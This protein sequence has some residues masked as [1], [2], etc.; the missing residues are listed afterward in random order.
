MWRE[1]TSVLSGWLACHFD[2]LEPADVS[3]FPAS[4]VQRLLD[5]RSVIH[6]EEAHSVIARQ[7]ERVQSWLLE[8]DTHARGVFGSQG[9][10]EEKDRLLSMMEKWTTDKLGFVTAQV[11]PLQEMRLKVQED[12]ESQMLVVQQHL[13]CSPEAA[14]EAVA[15]FEHVTSLSDSVWQ[16]LKPRLEGLKHSI[17]LRHED[18][19]KELSEA[20]ELCS[21]SAVRKYLIPA[22][23]VDSCHCVSRLELVRDCIKSKIAVAKGSL[24]TSPALFV[25]S[26]HRLKAA[27]N[28]VGDLLLK[29]DLE[30]DKELDKMKGFADDYV[31]KQ[32]DDLLVDVRNSNVVDVLNKQQ[33][34]LEVHG[35][36]TEVLSSRSEDSYRRVCDKVSGLFS[37]MS[38]NVNQFVKGLSA[39]AQS[40]EGSRNEAATRVFEAVLRSLQQLFVAKERSNARDLYASLL[41][42]LVRAI[43]EFHRVCFNETLRTKTFAKGIESYQCLQGFMEKGLGKHIPTLDFSIADVIQE[44]RFKHNSWNREFEQHLYTEQTIVEKIKPHLKH[45]FPSFWSFGTV[46]PLEYREATMVIEA[47]IRRCNLQNLSTLDWSSIAAA[48][49]MLC[50]IKKHLVDLLPE[51]I[52]AAVRRSLGHL[53][54]HF[55]FRVNEVVNAAG[56]G[57]VMHLEICF[58]RFSMLLHHCHRAFLKKDIEAACARVHQSILSLVNQSLS[59]FDYDLERLEVQQ[60]IESWEKLEKLTGFFATKFAWHVSD[61]CDMCEWSREGKALKNL[62]QE[63]FGGIEVQKYWEHCQ[64]LGVGPSQSLQEV[65]QAWK[66]QSLRAHPDQN[67]GKPECTDIQKQLNSAHHTLV[68]EGGFKRF[69]DQFNKLFRSRLLKLPEVLKQEIRNELEAGSYGRVRKLLKVL[70]DLQ[71]LPMASQD[72]PS[73]LAE[74]HLA[75]REEV[76]KLKGLISPLW[77]KQDFPA[78]QKVLGKLAQMEECF[79]AFGDIYTDTWRADVDQKVQ[80]KLDTYVKQARE[81][82][83]GSVADRDFNMMLFARQLLL[84]ARVLDHLAMYRQL[85]MFKISHLLDS[86]QKQKGG[87]C[88][89]F[90]LGMLLEQGKCGDLEDGRVCAEDQRLSKEIVSTFNHFS[91]VRTTIFNQQTASSAQKDLEEILRDFEVN[92][93]RNVA[94]VDAQVRP[95]ELKAAYTLYKAAYDKFLHW[96]RT[97]VLETCPDKIVDDIMNLAAQVAPKSSKV[98]SSKLK[99]SLPILLAGVGILLAGFCFLLCW[100]VLKCPTGR[101]YYCSIKKRLARYFFLSCLFIAKPSKVSAQ[102]SICKSGDRILQIAGST[103]GEDVVPDDVR[104]MLKQAHRTQILACLRLLGFDCKNASLSSHLMRIRTGEGKSIIVGLCAVVLSLLGFTSRCV[105]YSEYLSN[106]DFQDFL[107]VFQR[108]KVEDRVSYSK[109]TKFSEDRALARGNLRQFTEDLLLG[110]DISKAGRPEPKKTQSLAIKSEERTRPCK[111]QL[112]EEQQAEKKTCKRKRAKENVTKN[113]LERKPTKENMKKKARQ[114]SQAACPASVASIVP[115]TDAIVESSAFSEPGRLTPLNGEVILLVDEVDV[116]FGPD[117]FGK[118]YNQV[119]EVALPEVR[120]LL[121]MIWA[122]RS[123]KDDFRSLM[124]RVQESS[125]YAALQTRLADWDV[126]V[127]REVASMCAALKDM[128]RKEVQPEYIWKENRIGYKILDSVDADV[129]FGYTTAFHYLQLAESSTLRDKESALEKA[130]QL[131]I[132]CA[133][134]SYARFGSPK[135]LGVSGTVHELEEYK[136][137][138][139]TT[140]GLSCYSDM[141]SVYGD[142]N[143]RFLDQKIGNPI[144]VSEEKD[145][146]LNIAGSIRQQ[147]SAKR[148]VIAF[149]ENS[150]KLRDF[151]DSSH[152]R[153]LADVNVLQETLDERERDRVIRKAATSSQVTLATAVFGRGT[154]FFCHD[155]ELKEAGGVHVIQTFL[156][157]DKA[158]EV[159]I[160]GRTAR[161]GEDGSYAMVLSMADLE[162]FGIARSICT[163]APAGQ[164]GMLEAARTAHQKDVRHKVNEDG[165][166]CPT[167]Q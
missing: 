114:S 113:A 155:P 51:G 147:V 104:Q 36:L 69:Q 121:T 52:I 9:S 55:E 107:C 127:E 146:H 88:Y 39:M 161:Q 49:T 16:Q 115:E 141:P 60:A 66:A 3:E 120:N 89:L 65:I 28:D 162:D 108:F 137:E 83:E 24:E 57:E 82:L 126:V 119:A 81:Y 118:T 75:V 87:T 74:M 61:C 23:S 92:Q 7:F 77:E 136:W 145:H 4:A 151:L 112:E 1:L 67:A 2:G 142:K 38:E 133:R 21:F 144:T 100:N 78:L 166:N 17:R 167:Q 35:V 30:V 19:G 63:R 116:F 94:S 165:V 163:L 135:I 122:N 26:H 157:L 97:G 15:A 103:L 70:P 37:L 101:Y 138:I 90:K 98:W 131:Q 109:I 54:A 79:A 72:L 91:D 99:S 64:V 85:A 96:W 68:K 18:V 25:A 125:E 110:R 158:E 132:P 45:F 130:L 22:G 153:G 50:G 14:A 152:C 13:N 111:R 40:D 134:L 33:R 123:L 31:Q 164:C 5:V 47:T 154:D 58:R 73:L 27:M 129:S 139:L 102:Y 76:N 156:S 143:I 42:E 140:Y 43:H 124:R 106:R 160:K 149:F 32:C 41:N 95:E 29:V 150:T 10:Y 12:I 93:G 20:M 46:G 148:A 6:W 53:A 44:F 59:K 128:D 48:V 62:W 71:H 105:C 84:L 8:F 159:Q 117:F 34:L 56:T 80:S 86:A 11:M